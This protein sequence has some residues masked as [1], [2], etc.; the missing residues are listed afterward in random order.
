MPNQLSQLVEQRIVAYS[1]GHPGQ[2]P[3][4]IAAE[5]GRV[6]WGGTIVSATGVWRVLKRH[7][8]NTEAKRLAL[9]AGYQAPYQ[10]PR[11]R[12]GRS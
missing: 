11:D 6:K 2:G 5:I 1:L 10:P 3:D 8:L 7:G 9:I 4:R 12:S